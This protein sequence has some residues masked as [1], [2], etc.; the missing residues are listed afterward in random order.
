MLRLYK[1]KIHIYWISFYF[2]TNYTM[3]FTEF[4]NIYG[5]VISTIIVCFIAIAYIAYSEKLRAELKATR[6]IKDLRRDAYELASS[7]LE[8]TSRQVA[9]L[10]EKL[11]LVEKI[12]GKPSCKDFKEDIIR[13]YK[14]KVTCVDMATK[15]WLKADTIRKA[16]YRRGVK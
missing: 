7:S 14:N 6:I 4:W 15:Y 1:T 16:L 8:T 3:S 9:E 5:G 10:K 11:E 2:F 12:K 13:D